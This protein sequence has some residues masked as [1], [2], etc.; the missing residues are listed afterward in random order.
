MNHRDSSAPRSHDAHIAARDFHPTLEAPIM[1]KGQS[2][3]PNNR[4]AAVA[5]RI[6]G[7]EKNPF[8][9]AT[10]GQL[11]TKNASLGGRASG[12]FESGTARCRE[13]C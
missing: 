12:S 8:L 10:S 7:A 4:R 6:K 1:A 3:K 9:G 11:G 5:A 2:K 13:I